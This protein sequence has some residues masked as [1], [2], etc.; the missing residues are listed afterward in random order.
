MFLSA[1]DKMYSNTWH[2]NLE[3]EQSEILN[4]RVGNCVMLFEIE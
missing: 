1:Q 4:H 2:K 3:A